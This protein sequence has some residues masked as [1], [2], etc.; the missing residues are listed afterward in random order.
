MW[1]HPIHLH[2]TQYQ[3]TGSDGGRWPERQWRAETTEIVGVGQ[4]RRHRIHCHPWRLALHCHFSHHTMNAMGHD[5]PN[6]L[7]VD[8]S[9]IGREIQNVIPGYMPMG[10]NGMAEHQRHINMGHMR[11][12]KNTLPMAAG[13]WTPWQH[14]DGWHVYDGKSPR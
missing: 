8:Q 14:R 12:P 4:T 9:G 3:V 10:K 6:T 11:G 5:I 2:G 7:G 1:N 13:S